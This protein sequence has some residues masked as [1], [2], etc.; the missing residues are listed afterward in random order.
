MLESTKPVISV[1]PGTR[2]SFLAIAAA[3]LGH[4]ESIVRAVETFRESGAL[5]VQVPLD[6]QAEIVAREAPRLQP[7]GIT[8][9]TTYLRVK[10]TA[11]REITFRG[12][13]TTR[14]VV[15]TL[16]PLAVAGRVLERAPLHSS[17]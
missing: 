3:R 11:V 15:I 6:P 8:E 2:A 14:D 1:G 12:K 17:A 4:D 7:G 13:A 16:R 9:V 10:D 5:T